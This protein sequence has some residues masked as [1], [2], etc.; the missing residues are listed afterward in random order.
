MERYRLALGIGRRL[1]KLRDLGGQLLL[2]AIGLFDIDM[3]DFGVV[4]EIVARIIA[5]EARALH[6]IA[7]A[8]AIGRLVDVYIAL[9]IRRHIVGDAGR[10][11]GDEPADGDAGLVE[12]FGKVQDAV[13]AHGTPNEYDRL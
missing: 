13:A 10:I 3:N 4:L 6:D 1:R 9:D 12:H 2:D 8:H 7:A 11:V 5:V